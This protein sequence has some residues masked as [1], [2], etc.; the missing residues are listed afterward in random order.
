HD[1][2]VLRQCFRLN[3][4]S[5]GNLDS[6]ILI[7]DTRDAA[8]LEN[9][10]PIWHERKQL[11]PGWQQHCFNVRFQY[12]RLTFL[13]GNRRSSNDSTRASVIL[14]VTHYGVGHDMPGSP[15]FVQRLKC[16]MQTA[17]CPVGFFIEV[18]K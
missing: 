1:L 17:V 5:W 7:V 2:C 10:N 12:R 11:P 16:G 13:Y 9:Q 6:E 3:E 4:S 8:V 18:V 14:A 15:S